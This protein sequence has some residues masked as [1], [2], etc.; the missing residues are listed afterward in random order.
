MINQIFNEDCLEGAMGMTNNNDVN[1]TLNKVYEGDC[2]DLMKRIPDKSVNLLLT[3]IPYG[4][5]NRKSSGLRSLD[6]GVADTFDNSTLPGLISE[7]V[8]VTTDNIYVFCGTKQI[9]E[10]VMQFETHGLTTR[11]GAWSKTNPSPMNGTRLWVSGMEF[12][13]YARKPKA[14][15]NEHCKKALWEF[16]SG[17]SKVHPTQKP[18]KLFERLIQASSNEG[19]VVLDCFLGSGTTA[20]A[21]INTNRKFIGIEREAEYVAIANQRIYDSM[22]AKEEF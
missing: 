22:Q 8:R 1:L 12:C 2:L 9:S 7:F 5:V 19:D 18:I 20:V 11:V 13:V 16:P 4:E 6:K 14:T 15:H 17:Q 21:A 10:I 3:D